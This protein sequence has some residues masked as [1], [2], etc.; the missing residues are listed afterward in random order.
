MK[1]FNNT[2]THVMS[3]LSDALGRPLIF[4]IAVVLVAGWFIARQWLEYDLW[5]DI[6]D[7]TIFLTTF[8]F[9]FMLQ[10]SQNADTQAIQDKLDELIK[11]LPNAHEDKVAEE[12]E[13][14]HGDKEVRS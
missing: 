3:N 5:F 1:K 2:M 4:M 6:M 12:E 14:K 10:A 7:V 8:F 13:L 11:A 9:L